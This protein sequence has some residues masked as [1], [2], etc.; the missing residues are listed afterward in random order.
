M[1]NDRT[2]AQAQPAHAGEALR[3]EQR[4]SLCRSAAAD[5]SARPRAFWPTH[6]TVCIP[7]ASPLQHGYR[8]GTFFWQPGQA[9]CRSTRKRFLPPLLGMDAPCRLCRGR[10]AVLFVVGVRLAEVGEVG[11]RALTI[12]S[13]AVT[14]CLVGRES[15]HHIHDVIS[16]GATVEPGVIE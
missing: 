15:Q 3:L 10:Y 12:G 2:N 5:G 16:Q 9:S 13:D 14:Q 6:E 7:S 1:R 11:P 4:K 8:S